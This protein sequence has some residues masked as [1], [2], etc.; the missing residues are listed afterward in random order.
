MVHK[1]PLLGC[2][3]FANKILD[4]VLSI[5]KVGL[6]KR[7]RVSCNYA[8]PQKWQLQSNIVYCNAK[9]VFV[10]ILDQSQRLPYIY[11]LILGA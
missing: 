9:T 10:T 11:I 5:E 7:K 8:F 4:L 1:I 2:F 3:G 6:Y